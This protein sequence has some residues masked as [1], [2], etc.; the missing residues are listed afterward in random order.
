[1]GEAWLGI[2]A[3]FGAALGWAALDVLRKRLA[4]RMSATALLW[5][6]VVGQIPLFAA[7]VIARPGERDWTGYAAPGAATLIIALGSNLA[8]IRALEIGSLSRTVPILSVTP[9]VSVLTAATLL[10]E[11][12]RPA[13]IC[14]ILVVV[15]GSVLLALRNR[16]ADAQPAL[17]RFESGSLLVLGVAF[18]WALGSAV[19]KAALRFVSVPMHGFVQTI[20]LSVA[21]TFGL[22]VRPVGD[23]GENPWPALR[24]SIMLLLLAGAVMAIASALQNF[25]VTQTFVSVIETVKRAVGATAALVLGRFL[26]SETVGP[27]EWFASGLLVTGTAL[28]LLG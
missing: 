7:A 19:D 3:G 15:A 4:H 11:W 8:F 21:L 1:M 22:V 25:A 10:G 27:R 14:G 28:L 2:V 13:Q 9:A 17:F 26:F 5:A 16:S 24:A 18:A 6:L 20:G 23:R 12:P